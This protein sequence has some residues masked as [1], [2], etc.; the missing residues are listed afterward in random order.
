MLVTIGLCVKNCELTIQDTAESIANQ[1]FPPELAEVIVVDDGCKDRTIPIV[2]DRLSKAKMRVRV[3]HTGGSG[4]G[5]AR[6]IVVDNSQSKYI[7]WVDGD[8]ILSKDHMRKQVEFMEAHPDAGKARGKW[9]QTRSSK[10]VAL[11]ENMRLLDYE[12][13]HGGNRFA[14]SQLVGLGGSI[15]RL[16][17]LRQVDGFDLQITGAGEDVDIA[18]K[19]LKAGWKL[20]FSEGEFYHPFKETWKELWNQHLWYGYGAHFVGHRHKGLVQLWPR[21]PFVAFLSGLF[22][23]FAAYKSTRHSVSFLLPFQN[24]FKQTAWFLGFVKSHIENYGHTFA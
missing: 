6:Q 14:A 21:T 19:I 5:K 16:Q 10:V 23:S 7:L 20:K 12:S 4:L 11:L 18:A 8:M 9:K 17:A 1:D 24:A 3:Y 22:H 2:I 13:R 15:C